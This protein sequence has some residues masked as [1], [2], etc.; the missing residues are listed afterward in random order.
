MA[1]FVRPLYAFFMITGF[2]CT[3]FVVFLSIRMDIID[4]DHQPLMFGW[5]LLL[6]FPWLILQ[7]VLS[8]IMV[9]RCILSPRLSISPVMFKLKASQNSDLGKIVYANSIT[10][11]P[12]TITV[13]VDEE[14]FGVH[15]LLTEAADDLHEGEMDR[16]ITALLENK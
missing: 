15:A 5:K 3:V 6:Y 1:C 11:T 14:N 4:H 2:V 9:T 10:L 8:N 13:D 12:G 7:I 16:R